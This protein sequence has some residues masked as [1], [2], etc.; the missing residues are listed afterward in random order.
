MNLFPN[1]KS[2]IETGYFFKEVID[3][4]LHKNSIGKVHDING[5]RGDVTFKGNLDQLALHFFKNSIQPSKY[6]PQAIQVRIY[7]LNLSEKL[8]SNKN[9]YEGEIQLIM[10]FFKI[11]SNE[12]V[13]LID[14]SGSVNYRRSTN[15][16]DMIE[17]VVNRVF[18]AGLDYFNTWMNM[19]VGSN[20]HL[21]TSVRLEINDEPK[22]SNEDT[23]YYDPKRP[24]QWNDFSDRPNPKSRFNA[25]IFA[26]FSIQGRSLM[27]SGSIVQT[28]E[29]DVYMLPGQSWVRSTS[30]YALNHEQKHFDVARIVA[31]RLVS[32]LKSIELNP[33]WYE[34]TINDAYFDAY[35][36][37]NR[38]QEIYDKETG[39]GT[40]KIAQEKWNR[41]IDEALAGDWSW[42]EEVL[43]EK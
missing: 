21:A 32:K 34:A 28:I 2:Q 1:T 35:R 7:E 12:P 9:I 42:I 19:Q 38:L 23:V 10:G 8:S 20:R 22:A 31:D 13:Q 18:G 6:E 43:K 16:M 4:R 14:Y 3:F 33:D 41:M 29:L 40:D 5:N 26:S 15:R 27:E 36:E 30:D 37:M 25:S 24:L 39:H 11:G 17:N